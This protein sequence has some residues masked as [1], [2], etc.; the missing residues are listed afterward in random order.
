MDQKDRRVLL[1]VLQNTVVE[2]M[3][4]FLVLIAPEWGNYQNRIG[5]VFIDKI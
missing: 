1:V 4:F 2:F 3:R 5:S